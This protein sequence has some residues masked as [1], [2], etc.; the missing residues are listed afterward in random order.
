MIGNF[1]RV[2]L[3]LASLALFCN[4]LV[5]SV[6]ADTVELVGK[7]P[8]EGV[9]I[10]GFRT[11]RLHFRGQ[12]GETLRKP[13]SQ[14]ARIE[15]EGLPDFTA[16]ETCKD[17]ATALDRYEI[18]ARNA[19]RPWLRLLIRARMIS[20]RD[21]TGDF[22]GAVREFVSLV[23]DGTLADGAAA[24][25][26]PGAVGSAANGRARELLQSA[27]DHLDHA[28]A[29][30]AL[31]RLTL[32]LFIHDELEPPPDIGPVDSTP[33][34][35]PAAP[36]TA[37]TAPGRPRKLFGDA[38]PVA[39]IHP[40]RL[41]ADSLLFDEARAALAEKRGARA[42]RLLEPALP[43]FDEQT[44]WDVRLLLARARLDVG[45]LARAAGDLLALTGD[46]APAAIAPQA[47]Y[48]LARS[49]ERMQR[50]DLARQHYAA[51]AAHPAASGELTE[52]AKA[53]LER[54]THGPAT[55]AT[56]AAPTP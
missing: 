18:A 2:F 54:L 49:E 46:D 1:S 40:V 28:E 21:R 51:A 3:K 50:P 4:A 34:P 17:A 26:H 7:P 11:G 43:F 35:E 5:P 45:E 36:A 12:S 55:S 53:A 42:V 44:R 20:A 52:D 13:L 31:Y 29:Q 24:P 30:S 27:A 47:L 19:D 8:F 25:R 23:R 39:A 48:Y 16:A 14:V 10:V 9:E 15:I 22:E 33:K 41:T 56:Q 32:E 6:I 38:A 37:P